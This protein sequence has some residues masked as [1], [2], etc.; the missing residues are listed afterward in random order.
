MSCRH[1][2][3]TVQENISRN[4]VLSDTLFDEFT[5]TYKSKQGIFFFPEIV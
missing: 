3:F 1:F 2:M 4:G 5:R